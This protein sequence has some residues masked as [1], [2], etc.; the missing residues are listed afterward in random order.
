[1]EF[2][3]VIGSRRDTRMFLPWKPVEREK[4]QKMLETAL[5]SSRAVNTAWGKAVVTYRDW[6]TDEQR[7]SLKTP[8][9]AVEYDLAPVYIFWY[10]DM[11]ASGSAVREKR[12]PTVASGALVDV[13]ALNPT[14]GWSRRYVNNV[15]LPEVLTPGISRGLQRGGNADA[16]LAMEAA[17]LTAVDEGLGACLV[18]F[19]EQA[20]KEILGVPDTWEPVLAILVGYPAESLEG[21]G[22]NPSPTTEETAFEGTLETP[23]WRDEGVLD[24]LRQ[25]G[26]LQREAPMPWREEEVKRLG[27]MLGITEEE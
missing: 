20:A 25:E 23:F 21:M 1:M 11:D 27:K 12:W 8:I 4:I 18:P 5:L 24:R 9:G 19:V 22:Q 26:M 2:K 14:H 10:F 3:R 6:L 17:L 7:D 13:G 16:A 15:V